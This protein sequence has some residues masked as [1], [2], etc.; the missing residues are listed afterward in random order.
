MYT[1]AAENLSGDVL[2]NSVPKSIKRVHGKRDGKRDG[3]RIKVTTPQGE[4]TILA[5]KLII[6][7]APLIENLGALDLSSEEKS[8]F[9]QWSTVGYFA[10]VIEHAG[11]TAVLNNFNPAQP[12]GFATLPGLYNISP[13]VAGKLTFYGA[14]LSSISSSD[15]RQ[16]LLKQIRTL[17]AGGVIPAAETK[18]LF[19]TNHSPYQLRVGAQS[20]KDGFYR[21]LYGLQGKRATF[22]SGATWAAH[23]SSLIWEYTERE[24]IPSVI[25][26]LEE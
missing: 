3:V 21:D 1:A 17:E 4:K 24:V 2:Y 7:V 19:F 8:L 18:V 9:S 23:D 20:V 11:I 25:A 22:W 13:N 14:S 6:T 5:K 26:A 15:A 16:L 12:F 10:G